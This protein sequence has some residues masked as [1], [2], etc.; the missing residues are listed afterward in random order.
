MAGIGGHLLEFPP[1]G[2]LSLSGYDST[3]SSY[4]D[5]LSK[6]DGQKILK[7]DSE[8]NLLQV[9]NPGVNSIA[10]GYVLELRVTSF[11]RSKNQTG[12]EARNILL[13]CLNFFQLFDG[14][15]MRYA[16]GVLR[17][18]MEKAISIAANIDMVCIASSYVVLINTVNSYHK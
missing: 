12:T 9:L 2:E 4:V 13:Q 7:A 11:L 16:G 3:I 18:L 17:D 8:Q 15:Q 14:V 6:L 10:Y 5:S 1:D